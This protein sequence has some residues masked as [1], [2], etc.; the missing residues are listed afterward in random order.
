MCPGSQAGKVCSKR[1]TCV[2]GTCKC[3]SGYRGIGCEVQ[4]C[5]M[6]CSGNGH[7]NEEAAGGPTCECKR[8]WTGLGCEFKSC[9]YDPVA[10]KELPGCG[11]KEKRG[12]CKEGKCFCSKEWRGEYCA[13]P[14]CKDCN[15][16]KKDGTAGENATMAEQQMANNSKV[17]YIGGEQAGDVVSEGEATTPRFRGTT[18]SLSTD[19]AGACDDKCNQASAKQSENCLVSCLSGC[20]GDQQLG[21]QETMLV[22]QSR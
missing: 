13:T 18:S 19:C 16:D 6:G 12:V 20:N 10:K 8:G 1:G 2:D 14:A 15:D 9:T 7:C 4:T 21:A 22:Q 3:K 11:D 17:G 5:P